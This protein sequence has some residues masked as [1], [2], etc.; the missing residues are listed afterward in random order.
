[1][2]MRKKTSPTITLAGYR[3]GAT[4]EKLTLLALIGSVLAYGGLMLLIGKLILPLLI[5]AVV[6]L[7]CIGIIITGLRFAPVFGTL[8]VVSGLIMLLTFGEPF[9]TYE[10]THPGNFGIFSMFVFMLAFA[11]LG[12]GA[13][14]GATVQNYRA[15]ERRTPRWLGETLA[16]L[17]GIVLGMLLVSALVAANPPA[18]AGTIQASGEP[19][20]HMG[21]S[22]FVQSSVT[23]PKGSKLLLVS[24]GAFFHILADGTWHNGVAIPEHEPGAPSLNNLQV[25]GKSV[26]IGPFTTAGT[27]HI[28]CTIHQGMNL[29]IS[30]R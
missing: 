23:I 7:L 13:G 21:P 11:V 20:V 27:Y 15:P 1:M 22:N 2:Q 28:Y 10:L 16:G 18:S 30:V 14:V 17:A 24:D 25:N 19:T 5:L 3:A 29:T 12:T 8:L 4:F 9:A 6:M 26:E